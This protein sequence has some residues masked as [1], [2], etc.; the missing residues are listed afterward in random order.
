MTLSNSSACQLIKKCYLQTQ[1]FKIRIWTIQDVAL[2]TGFAV[3]T[4]YNKTSRREIPHR[5]RGKKLFFIP[6]EILNWIDEQ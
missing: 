2:F 4:I 3:G 6:D 5:K 1:L